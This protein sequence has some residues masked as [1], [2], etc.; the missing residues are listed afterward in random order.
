MCVFIIKL[1]N[2]SITEAIERYGN[3][4]LEE[5]MMSRMAWG[6]YVGRELGG[7][8]YSYLQWITW[9]I[10][11]LQEGADKVFRMI[12]ASRKICEMMSLPDDMPHKQK[13]SATP[14][15]IIYFHE[16]KVN[17]PYR[18][19]RVEGR[20]IIRENQSTR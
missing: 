16:N 3:L 5:A 18:T 15:D 14:A 1:T 2:M 9:N 4:S 7:I 19:P 13:Y 17:V 11:P 8:P 6:K 12:Y 20:Y 10:H